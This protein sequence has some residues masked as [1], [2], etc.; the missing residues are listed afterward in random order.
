MKKGALLFAFNNNSTDYYAMA[1]KTAKRINYFLDLPVSL[2]TDS[3]SITESD[4]TF[5]KVF[6]VD[7]DKS[8]IKN[9][10][11]WINKGRYQAFELS[12]Y[13]ETLLLDTDYLV[14]SNLLNLDYNYTDFLCPNKTN[15][16]LN[17]MGLEYVSATSFPTLW[18]TIIMFKKTKTT[19]HL[20]DCM[21]MVQDN[22]NHY[23]DLYN[24]AT[25]LYRNDYAL[26]IAHRLI[27]GHLEN[28][29]NYFPWLLNH[30]NTDITVKKLNDNEFNT[31]YLFFNQDNKGKTRYIRIT[32]TD[33]HCLHKSTFMEIA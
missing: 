18:A 8:N 33:F 3:N 28:K 20:F 24:I 12:P 22:Y 7:P 30:V 11:I 13:E 5:D 19:K 10:S 4:Y 9:K 15:F 1:V 27:N 25:S 21:R 32:N 2:V 14:N 6:L 16:I 17:D 23:I 31:D 29:S 26:A